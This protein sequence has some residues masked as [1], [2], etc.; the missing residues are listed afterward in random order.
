M[1]LPEHMEGIYSIDSCKGAF[2]QNRN[3]KI[4]LLALIG[5]WF[6]LACGC[7]KEA[8]PSVLDE[9]Q[10]SEA[11][12]LE[13]E[14]ADAASATEDPKEVQDNIQEETI[15]VFVCGQVTE[16]GVYELPEGSRIYQA[17]AAAGGFL[18]TAAADWLNQ[19]EPI[20]DGQKIYVP[21]LEEAGTMTTEQGASGTSGEG[22][23]GRVNL[24]TASRE[25]LMT[26]TGIGEKKADAIIQYRES[27]G[28]FQSVDELMQVEG[29]KEATYN[30]IK[31][32]IAI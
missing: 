23:D 5:I 18:D 9:V 11:E 31:D 15:C 3:H 24:N 26:L 17:V 21:T 13:K 20:Q 16:P 2:M 12:D 8:D 29:I 6:L 30:K 1:L 4:R 27:Q 32:R 19:A 28:G 22:T 25:E 14:D 10:I 7:R